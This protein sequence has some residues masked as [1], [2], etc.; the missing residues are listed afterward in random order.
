VNATESAEL[1]QSQSSAPG[2]VKVVSTVSAHALGLEAYARLSLSLAERAAAKAKRRNAQATAAPLVCDLCRQSIYCSLRALEYLQA[3]AAAPGVDT[4]EVSDATDV[5]KLL[6]RA[7]PGVLAKASGTPEAA[8]ALIDSI[9][10]RSF[11]QLAELDAETS[12]KLAPELLL[13]SRDLLRVMERRQSEIDR[14]WVR[15]VIFTLLGVSLALIALI[16]LIFGLRAWEVRRDIARGKP[17]TASTLY[18]S[19]GGCDSP[20]QDCSTKQGFFFHTNDEQ[21]PWF[22]IDLGSVQNVSGARVENRQDCCRE[23]ALPLILQVSADRK[24]WKE[25]ARQER[26]FDTWK[27]RFATERARYVRLSA[28][29]FRN[30]HLSRVRLFP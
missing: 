23:R 13:F 28:Q 2:A 30:L 19:A 4:V 5:D 8:Q 6:R 21:N 12:S 25:V 15:R 1:I 27:P 29:G 17:W 14:P 26:V 18:T 10:G 7:D 22:E 16:A 24:R 11:V 9:T 3:P 20:L